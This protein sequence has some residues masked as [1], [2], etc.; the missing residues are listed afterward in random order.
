MNWFSGLVFIFHCCSGCFWLL[1]IMLSFTS[2]GKLPS[3]PY[4]ESYRHPPTVSPARMEGNRYYHMVK[5]MSS[6]AIGNQLHLYSHVL[7]K[8][9]PVSY[10][11][12]PVCPQITWAKP[13]PLNQSVQRLEV[14]PG[15]YNFSVAIVTP[16]GICL[17]YHQ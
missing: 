9:N 10:Q 13:H 16:G 3:L 7:D 2:T 4:S 6:V 12:L 11:S 8:D 17:H 1:P 14:I 5:V 15:N